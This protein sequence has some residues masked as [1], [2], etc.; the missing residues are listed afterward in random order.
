LT[1]LALVVGHYHRAS[2]HVEVTLH[3]ERSLQSLSYTGS[4]PASMLSGL[5]ATCTTCHQTRLQPA[6]ASVATS[7]QRIPRSDRS[8]IARELSVRCPAVATATI[9]A[10]ASLIDAASPSS[11]SNLSMHPD[12]IKRRQDAEAR[13]HVVRAICECCECLA[14]WFDCPVLVQERGQKG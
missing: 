8:L 7:Q 11:D 10:S 12:A 1:V 4:A 9:A 6:R 13:Y 2:E 14:I 5:H 3:A